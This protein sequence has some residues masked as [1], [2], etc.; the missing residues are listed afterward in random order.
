MSGTQFTIAKLTDQAVA[1]AKNVPELV[2]GLQAVNP[3]LAQQIAGKALIASKTPWG[4]VASGLIG[5]GV[6]HWALGWDQATCDL[7]AGL[8]VLAG[9]YAMRY[10]TAAPIRGIVSTGAKS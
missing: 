4:T 3:G 7:V 5:W 9:S 2:A 10:I 1:E 8:C 6:S